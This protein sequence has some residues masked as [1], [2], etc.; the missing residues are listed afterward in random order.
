MI[1]QLPLY[2]T[3]VA[4]LDFLKVAKTLQDL[5]KMGYPYKV[6]TGYWYMTLPGSQVAKQEKTLT[7]RRATAY[8][9]LT[10]KY[11]AMTAD[12]RAKIFPQGGATK[13]GKAYLKTL[14]NDMVEYF[15]YFRQTHPELS[16]YMDNSQ[17]NEEAFFKD[18]QAMLLQWDVGNHPMLAYSNESDYMYSKVILVIEHVID[19]SINR[20][21]KYQQHERSRFIFQD[22]KK[23]TINEVA[24]KMPELAAGA[25][26]FIPGQAPGTIISSNA[27]R[28]RL[29]DQKGGVVAKGVNK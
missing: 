21:Y 26:S 13:E 5:Q 3:I 23:K 19:E 8:S 11:Q 25:N 22:E 18:I 24:A 20:Y 28:A 27:I 10:T 14:R 9:K 12:Q 16:K 7:A 1:F 6:Q 2:L 4:A 15:N 17:T 29:N